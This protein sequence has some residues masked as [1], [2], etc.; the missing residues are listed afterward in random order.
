MIFADQS[1]LVKSAENKMLSGLTPELR[2]IGCVEPKNR[3]ILE[4]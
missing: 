3:F 1:T 2:N 4:R